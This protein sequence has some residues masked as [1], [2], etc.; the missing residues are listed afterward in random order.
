MLG[1][2][3]GTQLCALIGNLEVA[4]PVSNIGNAEVRVIKPAKVALRKNTFDNVFSSFHF[5]N[6]PP[7]S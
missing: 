3:L 7:R 5:G 1:I 2:T 6:T 4:S